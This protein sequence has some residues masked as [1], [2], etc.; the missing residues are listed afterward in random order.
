MHFHAVLRLGAAGPGE[1]TSG[2]PA[3]YTAGLLARVVRQTVP[4]VSTPR[5]TA[6]GEVS[7]PV[8]WGRQLDVR[9]I[10]AASETANP[11]AI[12][13]YVAKYATKSSTELGHTLDTRL[14]TAEEI[15]ALKVPEHVRRLVEA[16]WQLGGQPHLAELQLRRWAHMLGF[17]GHFST[18]SRRYSTTLTL[19]RTARADHQR[20][21]AAARHPDRTE[22]SPVDPAVVAADPDSIEIIS[23]WRYAGSGY[24]TEGD[25]LL[26]ASAAD[27]HWLSWEEARLSRR[28]D[29]PDDLAMLVA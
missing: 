10:D 15:D 12:A 16:C 2:P 22:E 24:R 13:A 25:R 17:R 8:C 23:R 9:V 1:P 7:R 26:A 18:R 3:R 11:T 20:A 4:Q 19:L 27:R 6:Q 14:R 28:T 5:P 29:D 21:T